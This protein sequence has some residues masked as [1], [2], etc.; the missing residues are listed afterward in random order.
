MTCSC[1]FK[2][3]RDTITNCSERIYSEP[4]IELEGAADIRLGG[5][6]SRAGGILCLWFGVW[7]SGAL[8]IPVCKFNVEAEIVVLHLHDESCLGP[9]LWLGT[10][11]L[12][13]WRFI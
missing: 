2:T 13:A 7:G 4:L 9:L 10:S 8:R 12:W 5:Y 11:G 6:D 3:V 1:V